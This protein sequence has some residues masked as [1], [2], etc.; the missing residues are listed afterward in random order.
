M[1]VG[2]P[3]SLC[4]FTICISYRWRMILQQKAFNNMKQK[5]LNDSAAK[6]KSF[7]AALK[8]VSPKKLIPVDRRD[9]ASANASANAFAT[10]SAASSSA[11]ASAK[12]E[13]QLRR[14]T[15]THEPQKRDGFSRREAREEHLGLKCLHCQ[16]IL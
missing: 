11:T 16:T 15:A 1:V 12:Q 4:H 8:K 7:K 6:F 9:E 5:S 13:I 14:S 10:A 3:E 2:T